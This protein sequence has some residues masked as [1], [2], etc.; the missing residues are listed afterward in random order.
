MC[1]AEG[2]AEAPAVEKESSGG[3]DSAV[4]IRDYAPAGNAS[5]DSNILVD[6]SESM[7][8]VIGSNYLQN[9]FSG[10]YMERG[11]GV[12][13][14]KRFYYKGKNFAGQGK[15]M[16]SSMYEGIVSLEDITFT[17]FTHTKKIGYLIFAILLAIAA[18][19]C[20]VPGE[21]ALYIVSGI[22]ASASV[23]FFIRY[24]TGRQTIF[25]VSFPGGGFAFNVSWYPIAE[26]R[27]F[28]RQLHL[29]KDQIK[30][31]GDK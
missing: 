27:D 15:E 19:V 22:T 13:T 5:G 14:Q 11:V 31:G 16:A 12:L 17:Q 30:E 9:F 23:L 3:W 6:Q 18:V 10:G 4:E 2:K 26:F 20:F 8:A 25:K 21:E 1:V 29:L 7:V 24:F 28:Q